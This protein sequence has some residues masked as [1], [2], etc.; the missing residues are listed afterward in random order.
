MPADLSRRDWLRA[1]G[2]LTGSLLL[3]AAPA[4]E[5]LAAPAPPRAKDPAAPVRLNGNE[6]PW[7]PSDKARQ[8]MRAA[9]DSCN[10]YPNDYI[11]ALREQIAAAEG[12]TPEHVLLGAGSTELLSVA[13]LAYGLEGG[14]LVSAYPAFPLLMQYAQHFRADWVKVPLDA[15]HVHDLDAMSQR[16]TPQTRLV[17][18]C[19][20]NNPT[21]TVL[22]PAR[23][24]AFCQRLAGRCTVLVDEAYIEY[25]DDPAG[26]T[27]IDL[28]KQGQDLIV[29]RTFS[30]IYGLAGLR[31]GYAL[32]PPATVQRLARYQMGFAWGQGVPAL[33]AAQ[34]SL[35]DP[36]FVRSSRRQTAAG[37][38]QLLGWLSQQ[39]IRHAAAAANFV[40]LALDKFPASF[41]EDLARRGLL[42]GRAQDYQ[43]EKWARISIGTPEQMQRLTTALADLRRA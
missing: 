34:A 24:R 32:A 14:Q 18:V 3:G 1:S 13:G 23:L 28:V 7:G 33:A 30:K 43:G 15:Q 41:A 20:P 16:V 10:R 25:L 17:Y 22:P 5:L 11:K 6:N 2:L 37:R 36:D 21:G 38:Q 35:A 8:A 31:I 39:G 12:L 9:F 40:F 42:V 26:H 19:N 27:M 4:A 29:L